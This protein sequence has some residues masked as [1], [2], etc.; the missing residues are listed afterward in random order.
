MATGGA[1]AEDWLGLGKRERG[2]GA[3]GTVFESPI[4]ILWANYVGQSTVQVPN[5]AW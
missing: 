3:S 1:P 2:Q 4:M 5:V